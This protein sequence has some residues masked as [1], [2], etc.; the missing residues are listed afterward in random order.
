MA[1]SRNHLNISLFLYT[2]QKE[3]DTLLQPDISNKISTQIRQI[4]CSCKLLE[5]WN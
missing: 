4:S 5:H 3:N 1:S 2:M